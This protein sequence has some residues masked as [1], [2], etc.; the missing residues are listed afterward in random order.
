MTGD[1]RRRVGRLLAIASVE[2]TGSTLL[3]SIL[4]Q[5]G[6]AGT[7]IEYLNIQTDNFAR[8]REQ[9]GVPRLKLHLRPLGALRR[10]LGRRFAWRNIDWFS[11]RSWHDYLRAIAARRATD[12]GIFGIKMHWNQYRRHMLEFG[13][14][15]GFWGVPVSWVRIT[16]QDEIRQA[17]SFV[18]AD[19][20]ESWNS[21]MT[22][23]REPTYD[24]D[25]IEAALERIQQ[26]ND[27]WSRYFADH[28]ITPLHITYEQLTR[29]TDST[30]RAIMDFVGSPVDRVPATTT[31]SQSD[32]INA[33]WAGRFLSERPHHAHRAGG[34]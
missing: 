10:K 28:G 8:F 5:T 33:E 14:D 13:L 15:V 11:E 32:G 20:T 22:A 18:R 17:I 30:I 6:A 2:R 34:R 26:E 1:D 21:S 24:A 4:R 19:Q 31:R 27:A 9:S 7:P 25:A 3:C 12:N 16:R 23:K 29:D